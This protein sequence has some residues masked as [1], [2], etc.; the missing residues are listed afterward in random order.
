MNFLKQLLNLDIKTLIILGLII[1]LLLRNCDGMTE[2]GKKIVNVN[3][4]KYEL[5]D[6]KIDTVV[7]E[8]IVNVPTYVPKYITR[9]E[10]VEVEI[11]FNVDTLEIVKNYF[12]TFQIKDTLDLTYDFPKNAKDSLGQKPSPNLGWGVI[13]DNISQ[14]KITSRDIEWNFKIPTIFNTT[15]VKE[16]PKNQLYYGVNMGLNKEDVFSNFNGGL[17]LKTKSN[18]LYQ[19]NLGV[20]NSPNGVTPYLGG[21]LYWKINLKK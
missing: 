1:I 12:A 3:G 4:K 19:L 15:I 21:G 17:I 13:T 20:Q 18:K 6:K 5:L 7:V 14:N 9:L 11:P 16:L 10:T 8:K 2:G